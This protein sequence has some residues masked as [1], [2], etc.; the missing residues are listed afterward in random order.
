MT[1]TL[2]EALHTHLDRNGGV[3]VEKLVSA[4]R[5]EYSSEAPELSSV[6]A[7]KDYIKSKPDT[8]RIST[9]VNGV[10]RARL[11]NPRRASRGLIGL[12]VKALEELVRCA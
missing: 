1:A 5:N 2:E 9:S 11:T 12:A 3:V 10:E 8:F 6:D 7:L 4:M